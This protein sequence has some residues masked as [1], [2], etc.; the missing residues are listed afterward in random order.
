MDSSLCDRAGLEAEATEG[1]ISMMKN[2]ALIRATRVSAFVLFDPSHS[3][4]LT[5]S[6]LALSWLQRSV[7]FLLLRGFEPPTL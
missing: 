7:I 3:L 1:S 5:S 4:F 2:E 6:V